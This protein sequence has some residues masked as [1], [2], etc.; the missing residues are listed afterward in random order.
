M[1]DPQGAVFAL[2]R[3]RTPTDSH[4][5]FRALEAIDALVAASPACSAWLVQAVDRGEHAGRAFFVM[6][7][8]ES[9]LGDWMRAAWPLGARLKQA[10]ALCRLVARFNMSSPESVLISRASLASL[11]SRRRLNERSFS[12]RYD[13]PK[14]E[15]DP[16]HNWRNRKFSRPVTGSGLLQSHPIGHC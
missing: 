6:P 15:I 11:L 5:L 14:R 8:H 1:R 2:Q 10:A 13:I 9:S 16:P 12:Q 7:W 4:R 3:A